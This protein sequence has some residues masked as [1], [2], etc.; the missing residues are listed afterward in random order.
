MKFDPLFVTPQWLKEFHTKYPHGLSVLE[1]IIEWVNQTNELI[2][3]VN[4]TPEKMGEILAQWQADGTL[5]YVISEALQTEIDTVR[6]NLEAFILEYN[7]D[8]KPYTPEQFGAAGD[9][10]TDDSAALAAMFAAAPH[11]STII[12]KGS[13]LMTSGVVITK[14]HNI[15]GQNTGKL[16]AGTQG[17]NNLLDFSGV[18]RMT[19]RDLGIDMND[20][21]RTAMRFI[22]CED[23]LIDHCTF[24]GYTADYGY[25]QTDSAVLL[26][27]VRRF[28]VSGCTFD[29]FG[30]GYRPNQYLVRSVTNQPTDTHRGGVIRNNFFKNANQ[31]IVSTGK[32][33]I[34]EGNQFQGTSDNSVYLVGGSQNVAIIGNIFKDGTDED[35]VV[36]GSD[37]VIK[38][39]TFENTTN[40]MVAINNCDNLIIDGNNFHAPL[41]NAG[42]INQRD[43]NRPCDRLVITNNIIDVKGTY[44]TMGQFSFFRNVMFSNNIITSRNSENNSSIVRF[45][46]NDGIKE[47]L[48]ITNNIIKCIKDTPGIDVR[49]IRIDGNNVPN[50]K[51]SGNILINCGYATYDPSIVVQ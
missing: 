31:G 27:S 34:I 28:I 5:D 15:D 11:G 4:V 45:T 26:N 46:G 42:V 17:I 19:V 29:S 9:G 21:G 7:R 41:G 30:A 51:I 23:L 3:W 50:V 36:G 39:N 43:T 10:L 24:R 20:L 35:V 8:S 2:D 47:N 16:V 49:G 18:S 37:I 12:L 22:D 25:Y 13:Y 38:G 44:I 48:M 32:E 33:L 1:N 14:A 40:K 6:D